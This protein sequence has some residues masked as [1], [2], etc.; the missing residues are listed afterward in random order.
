MASSVSSDGKTVT[1][2]IPVQ[3]VH[4][5]RIAL[6]CPCKSTKSA[7]TETYRKRLDRALAPFTRVQR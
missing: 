5:L 1:I 2:K 4:T 6:N 7:M 3:D